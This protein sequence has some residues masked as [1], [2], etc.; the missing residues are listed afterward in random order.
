MQ[1]FLPEPSYPLSAERLDNKRLGKQRVEA[2]QILRI[3]LGFSQ[4][5]KHHP[6]VRMWMNHESQLALYGLAMCREWKRRGFRDSLMPKFKNIA[7][8]KVDK[9]IWITKEF[10]ESHR[11]NLIRKDARHYRNFWPETPDD[12]PYVWPIR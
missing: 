7:A 1:T 10:C 3:L 2:W 5:W 6:A 8:S 9:P 11:S 12:L 4:E